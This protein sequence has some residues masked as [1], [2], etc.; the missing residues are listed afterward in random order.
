MK[1]IRILVYT[2][3]EEWIRESLSNRTVVG[4]F[5]AFNGSIREFYI[6]SPIQLLSDSPFDFEEKKKKEKE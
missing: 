5:D 3:N 6:Q 1:L 4:E 2:G